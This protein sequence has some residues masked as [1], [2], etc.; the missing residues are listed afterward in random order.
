MEE[1]RPLAHSSQD[2]L[3]HTAS[4]VCGQPCSDCIQISRSLHA[5]CSSAPEIEPMV[6]DS[7]IRGTLTGYWIGS[8][9]LYKAGG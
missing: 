3:R 2:G 1:S 4:I 6:A 8:P 9:A 5:D 7:G